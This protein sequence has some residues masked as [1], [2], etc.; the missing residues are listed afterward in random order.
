M[1]N[2]P[3]GYDLFVQDKEVATLI[4]NFKKKFVDFEI[5]LLNPAWI[6]SI[7]TNCNALQLMKMKK[8]E[9]LETP[10]FNTSIP[11]EISE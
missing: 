6:L 10:T 2:I 8:H 1:K 3:G 5:P 11:I 7:T 4:E 9:E